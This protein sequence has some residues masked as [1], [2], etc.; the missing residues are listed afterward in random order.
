MDYSRVSIIILN[1]NGWKDTI[2]CLESVYQITY[3]N[4][5]VIVVDNGSKDDSVQKI[6]EY[7]EGKVRVKSKFFEYD[8]SNKPIKVFEM[9]E[10]EAKKGKFKRPL[11]E[12]FDANRRLIL[13]KNKNN[14]G[15]AGGNNIGVRCA[16]EVLNPNYVLL[17]NNDTVVDNKF[18]DELIKVA[19]KDEKIGIVGPKI[20]YYDYNGR[21]DVINFAGGKLNLWKGQ[22]YHIGIKEID[23]GQYDKIVEVDYIEGSCL[24]IK[25]KILNK[26]YLFDSNYFAYWEDIDLCIRCRRTGYIIIYVPTAKIWHKESATSGRVGFHR[27]YYMTRNNFIFMKKYTTGRQLLFFI[28]YFYGFRFWFESTIYL[29]YYRNIK[30]FL[31]FVK[32]MLDGFSIYPQK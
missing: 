9:T 17:L 7:C 28:L 14:Y 26:I 31:Y 15:F 8:L 27:V 1:W 4:Y 29:L 32:G 6:K 12:K 13:I 18:L 24:L 23:R 25:R 30:S 2:E 10:D 22:A 5:D 11:Y 3:P 21:S 16:L 20:Y 19:E